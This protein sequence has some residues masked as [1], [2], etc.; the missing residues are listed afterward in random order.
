MGDAR[1]PKKVNLFA[2]LLS[3]EAALFQDAKERL[4]KIFG[5]IDYEGPEMN[6]THTEYYKDEMGEA[7]KRKFL[8]FEKLI[9]PEDIC[10]VKIMTNS[11]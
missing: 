8:S 1:I 5:R 11:L 9:D 6:F 3:N 10:S 2:G 7:L 4:E